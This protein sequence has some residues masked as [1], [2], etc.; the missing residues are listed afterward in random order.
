MGQCLNRTT[1]LESRL[2]GE[3]RR[4]TELESRLTR[5]QQRDTE[6]ES[7]LEREQQ[8]I[9]ELE[10]RLAREQERVTELESELAREQERVT[11]LE[12]ELA[13][14]QQ[15]DTELE[16]QLA[17][18]QERVTE[19]ESQLVREQQ[20][21]TELESLAREQQRVT[22]L[23]SQLAREQER[24]PYRKSQSAGKQQRVTELESQLSTEQER[25]PYRKSKSARKRKRVTEQL[26]RKERHVTDLESQLTREQRRV[27]ELEGQSREA[28]QNRAPPRDWVITPNEIQF[29]TGLL[30]QGAW[31][32]VYRGKFHG[33]DVAVKQMYENIMSDYNRHLFER[34]VDI[35]SKCRHPCLLQFI[36][37]TTDERPLLVTEIMDCSLRERLFPRQDNRDYTPLSAEEV[38]VISL[39][40]ARALNYLHQKREPI[41]HHDISSANVLLW[42]HG[43]QWRAKVSD[44]GTANFVRQSTINYAGALIYCAPESI[45]QDPDHRISC[46]VSK[47]FLNSI[48]Y[49]EKRVYVYRVCFAGPRKNADFRNTPVLP[50]QHGQN[51]PCV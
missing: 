33:C 20:R 31:G 29:M 35:A 39:D 3:R 47:T 46:K 17:K 10:S 32:V 8:R 5:V 26:E 22:E 42:R 1:E 36:G 38:S 44:Y 27:T 45:N 51:T 43:D 7:Q 11:E 50:K 30:G 34:E 49:P 9:T 15:R 6:L 24:I 37:A 14:E 18:E 28:Q 12:S 25:I 19:L 23:E 2:E 4:I 13:R 40:V 21:D 16:S 41:I 48:R